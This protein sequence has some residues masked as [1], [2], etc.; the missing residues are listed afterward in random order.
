MNTG[1]MI[2]RYIELR[3]YVAKRQEQ[4][5]EEIKPY[6]TGMVAIENAVSAQIIEL[7][8][9]SIKTEH[10]TAYRSTIMA[11]KV[12]SREEF[13]RFVFEEQREEF[14]TAAVAKEAVKDWVDKYQSLPPGIDVTYVHKTNFRKS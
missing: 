6:K 11:T 1:E 5:D 13:M 9:E 10:G 12:A 3:A 4:F 7:G 8:G 2:K 14:L